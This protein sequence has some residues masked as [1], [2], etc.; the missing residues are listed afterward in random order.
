MISSALKQKQEWY[1]NV[2]K[3]M[4]VTGDFNTSDFD[5]IFQEMKVDG[6]ILPSLRKI[7]P[8][9]QTDTGSTF[10]GFVPITGI[11]K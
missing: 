9:E 8:K 10:N 1:G 5:P 3:D 6:H 4:L 7:L 2:L 11:L